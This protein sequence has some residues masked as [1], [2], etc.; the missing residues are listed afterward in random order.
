MVVIEISMLNCFL[1]DA[2]FLGV[3]SF[4]TDFPKLSG[5]FEFNQSIKVFVEL[6][7]FL[8]IV[9][10]SNYEGCARVVIQPA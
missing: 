4:I 1:P 10:T 8:S 2:F 9:C 7:E 5:T 3:Y 6:A